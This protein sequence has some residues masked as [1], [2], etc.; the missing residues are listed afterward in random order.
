MKKNILLF[1]I[2]LSFSQLKCQE[3]NRIDEMIAS[4]VNS[5]IEWRK[6]LFKEE[7]S[8]QD[9]CHYYFC[10]DGFP[11]NFN[12]INESK[13]NKNITFLSFY[14][15]LPIK[16]ELKKG[17]GVVFLGM[18]IIDNQLILTLTSRNVRLTKNGH[19]NMSL[20]IWKKYIYEYSCNK[21]KWILIEEKYGGV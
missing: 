10:I 6:S 20:T 1:T 2:F 16:K 11:Y 18:E 5:Y 13:I 15:K 9:T 7:I 4:S 3:S 19:L 8:N 21:Q 12:Y 17:I 14:N